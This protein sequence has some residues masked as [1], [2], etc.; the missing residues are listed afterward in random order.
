[1]STDVR[2]GDRLG[3]NH[4]SYY[5]CRTVN[6]AAIVGTALDK[7]GNRSFGCAAHTLHTAF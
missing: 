3:L 5:E 1:V 2:I 7:I 4:A 6:R